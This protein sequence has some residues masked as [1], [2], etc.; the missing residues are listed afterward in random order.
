[1][2]WD[3]GVAT[4]EASSA[5]APTG[6][7]LALPAWACAWAPR[8]S[9]WST[10]SPRSSAPGRVV[11][12]G[13]GLGRHR[14]RRDPVH[15]VRRRHGTTIDYIADIRLG[16]VLRLRPAVPGPAVRCAGP[17]RGRGDEEDAGRAAL[18]AQPRSAPARSPRRETPSGMK[19]AVVGSGVSG[20]TAAWRLNQEHEV[21]LYEGEPAVGGHVK[22]VMVDTP[23]GPLAVDTGFIVYNEVTYPRFVVDARGAG[24]RDAAQRTCPSGSVCRALRRR[25]QHAGA[26]GA[27]RA[28]RAGLPAGPVAD[29]RGHPAVLPRRPRAA[30]RGHA[31]AG[32]PGRVPRRPAASGASSATTSWCP[33]RRRSGPPR[34]TGSSTSRSTTC[35]T[36]W[37]TTG[38]S[39]GTRAL[40]W[41]TITGGS[42]R[43]V[44]AILA[45]LP[46]A[47]SGPATRSRRSPATRGRHRA[48]PRRR[49]RSG[50]TRSSWPPTP[51]TRWPCSRTPTRRSGRDPGRLRLH[52]QR[53]R[54]PHRCAP[55][56][57][58]KRRAWASWN[59]EMPDC[60]SLGDALTMT[61]HMNRLQSLSGPRQY[62]VSVNP[63]DR[64]AGRPGHRRAPHEPP[65]V[66][67][68]DARRPAGRGRAPGSAAAPGIAGA[69]LGYG[70]HED[71]CR[72]GFEVAEA[73]G[74]APSA[75]LAA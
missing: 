55:A 28:A 38:S 10:A 40:Q 7:G 68:P 47:R 8:S 51:T 62:C 5:T 72:S 29:D 64:V 17:Q 12:A 34:P 14:D 15:A 67:V 46:P 71:G 3:P 32:H 66:H 18:D 27:V 48:H 36:S 37:T 31:R 53:G 75:R 23:G 11:L 69:H 56:A 58:G 45:T 1:M 41:R 33:S 50:S 65:D 9:P 74:A 22:T 26:A 60:R 25:V 42:Q 2:H 63:G 30:R 39:A 44:D 24:R 19:V 20:L 70:F 54:A 59:V 21:A 35:S 4:S 43:Y 57:H 16:G 73:I 6:A 13:D 52:H 49:R 61:Y